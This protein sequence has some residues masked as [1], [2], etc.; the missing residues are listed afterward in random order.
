[1]KRNSSLLFIAALFLSPPVS[2][3]DTLRYK[4]IIS[5]GF[6]GGYGKVLSNA[7][8]LNSPE[9][10]QVQYLKTTINWQRTDQ[11]VLNM[12]GC[13]PRHMLA[14]SY[15]NF[16][17]GAL[18]KGISLSYSLSPYFVLTRYVS[19]YPSISIGGIA[20][21]NPFDPIKNAGNKLYSLSISA[22][23][24]LGGG[25]RVQFSD[26]WAMH[27]IAE[28]NH[29]S[30]GGW[31]DP[32]NG[33]NWPTL[34]IGVEY[35]P[36]GLHLKRLYKES[37]STEKFKVKRMDMTIFGLIRSGTIQNTEVNLP[38]L[39]G[40]ALVSKQMSRIHAWT[41][42]TEFYQDQLLQKL[43][44]AGNIFSDGLRIGALAGHEF[45]LGKFIFSQQVG[46][47]LVG[48]NGVEPLYHRWGLQYNLLPKWRI[49]V[50]LRAYKAVAEFTDVRLT[51]TIFKK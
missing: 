44:L 13:F 31:H 39:G 7:S 10:D 20:L 38:V 1:M 48:R 45:L 34:G 30:N 12:Y 5:F 35:S 6:T 11:E 23:V 50:N 2:A 21:S 24:A 51:Y 16:N 17:N 47:Y 22:Y 46:V 32:N 25:M 18:G 14:F 28:Y 36:K 41:L 37:L 8:E 43:L 49:G 9:N 27:V 15:Y 42:S 29:V 33:V 4:S 40:E 19:L 26:Y 3:Q